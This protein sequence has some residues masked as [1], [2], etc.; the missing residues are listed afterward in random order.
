MWLSLSS[1]V[2]R[3]SLS[4]R[5]SHRRAAN[6]YQYDDAPQSLEYA[7]RFPFFPPIPFP[8]SDLVEVRASRSD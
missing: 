8:I 2:F 4:S 7:L 6:L 1:P 5:L 3:C